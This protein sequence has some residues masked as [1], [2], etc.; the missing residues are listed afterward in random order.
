MPQ[1]YA[2]R[3]EQFT[4]TNGHVIGTLLHDVMVGDTIGQNT[5]EWRIEPPQPGS[6][7]GHCPHCGA[8]WLHGMGALHFSNGWRGEEQISA[9]DVQ[10]D[11]EF[12]RWVAAVAQTILAEEELGKR[13][14]Y[15]R[16]NAIAKRLEAYVV[17]DELEELNKLRDEA[18][19]RDDIYGRG[20]ET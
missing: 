2:R 4:C 14:V 17:M 15:E 1:L 7:I 16:L 12:L 6:V 13:E 8:M 20:W 19:E 18:P 9:I 3:G 5:V 11:A 10:T